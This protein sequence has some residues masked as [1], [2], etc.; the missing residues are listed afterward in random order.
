MS[1]PQTHDEVEAKGWVERFVARRLIGPDLESFEA[2]LLE[3]TQ[4]QTEVRVGVAVAARFR[5]APR[6]WWRIAAP[7]A[8]AAILAVLLWPSHADEFRTLGLVAEPPVY[9]AVEVRAQPLQPGESL[10]VLGAA[11]YRTR[12]WHGAIEALTAAGRAGID[13]PAL[14]FLLGISQLMSGDAAA[15]DRTLGELLDRDAGPYASEALYYQAK[16]RLRL[17]EGDRALPL[18]RASGLPSAGPLADTVEALLPR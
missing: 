10:F 17:G 1:R 6:R 18:L 15:A 7:L 3:C 8:A 16:A 12:D 14:R 4:C 5:A 13:A 9:D 11:A 2:H